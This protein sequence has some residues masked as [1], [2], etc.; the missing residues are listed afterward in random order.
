MTEI[1][2]VNL[3]DTGERVLYANKIYA[4]TFTV[5]DDGVSIIE[6]YLAGQRPDATLELDWDDW[7]T[8]SM[9]VAEHISHGE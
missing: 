4:V 7:N 1:E 8:I 6:R 2:V 9:A 3:E 5:H